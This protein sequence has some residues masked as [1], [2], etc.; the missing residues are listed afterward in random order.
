MDI[1]LLANPYGWPGVRA[2]FTSAGVDDLDRNRWTGPI[3]IGGRF[4]SERVAG[5]RHNTHL[6]GG[7]HEV[8][9]E[10]GN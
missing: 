7:Q 3:G 10:T 2:R 4:R 6:G 8:V 1:P 9:V 5:F